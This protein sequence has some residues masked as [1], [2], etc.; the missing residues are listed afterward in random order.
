MQDEDRPG[1]TVI[2]GRRTVKPEVNGVTM[3]NTASAPAATSPRCAGCLLPLKKVQPIWAARPYL[4]PAGEEESFSLVLCQDCGSLFITVPYVPQA[5]YLYFLDWPYSR[6]FWFE[7]AKLEAGAL[8]S[9]W[10][11]YRIRQAWPSLSVEEKTSVQQSC[12]R[13]LGQSI[14]RSPSSQD[15]DPLAPYVAALAEL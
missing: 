10:C 8:L 2:W 13:S 1:P 4:Y 3:H 11:T 7:V 14:D 15:L 9:P 5:S 6:H 12:K